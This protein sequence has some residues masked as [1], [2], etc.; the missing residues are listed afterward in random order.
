MVKGDRRRG[1][2]EKEK[3]E[4]VNER[5][6]GGER[7]RERERERKRKRER[8]GALRSGRAIK[9]FAHKR[10]AAEELNERRACRREKSRKERR[11][12]NFSDASAFCA[13]YR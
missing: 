4:D 7:E 2:D 6:T 13:G 11:E 10:V 5:G 8:G 1:Q 9:V 3:E 12:E